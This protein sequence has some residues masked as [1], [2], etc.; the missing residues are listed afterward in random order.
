ML[1]IFT[2]LVVLLAAIGIAVL[3]KRR[4]DRDLLES[5]QPKNLMDTHLRPLFE[6]GDEEVR[7]DAEDTD[8]MEA[9]PVDDEREKKLAKLVEFRQTW[10]ANPNKRDTVSLLLIA[11]ECASASVYSET[12]GEVLREWRA[13]RLD[14]LASSDLAELIETHL[15]LLPPA[16][17]MSGEAFVVKQ[18]ISDLRSK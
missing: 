8:V 16:E 10:K 7:S 5:N 17:R 3:V 1:Y 2:I 13:K 18:E 12:V 6:A 11:S 15:W 14:G 4:I 9:E